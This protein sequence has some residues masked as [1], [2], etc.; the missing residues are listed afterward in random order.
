LAIAA[1][2]LLCFPTIADSNKRSIKSSA[3]VGGPATES[4]ILREVLGFLASQLAKGDAPSATRLLILAL[5]LDKSSLCEAF[6]PSGGWASASVR[7]SR[8]DVQQRLDAGLQRMVT[9]LDKRD[10]TDRVTRKG[11]ASM[12][13]LHLLAARLCQTGN[14]KSSLAWTHVIMQCS[15]DDGQ[16]THDTNPSAIFQSAVPEL[17]NPDEDK[18]MFGAMRTLYM[19]LRGLQSASKSP[20]SHDAGD[21]SMQGWFVA[22]ARLLLLIHR[23]KDASDVLVKAL[24]EVCTVFDVFPPRMCIPA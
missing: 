7:M 22:Q 5:R 18:A 1:C 16:P 13:I 6:A 2:L 4:I 24:Q 17:L 11:Q 9:K 21:R 3:P 10:Q 15:S 8:D 20:Q 23:Y 12:P 14:V 19:L